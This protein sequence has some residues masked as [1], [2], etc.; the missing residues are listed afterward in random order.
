MSGLTAPNWLDNTWS[1]VSGGG[2]DVA[3]VSA[4][5]SNGSNSWG[6]FFQNLIG[7]AV[8]YAVQKDAAKNNLQF[9]G[10]TQQP[11]QYVQAPAA[12]P[13]SSGIPPLVMFGGLGLLAFIALKK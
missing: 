3:T 6:G 8:Q 13:A 5:N 12:A 1:T 4:D 10:A 2:S 11:V 7:G 9:G